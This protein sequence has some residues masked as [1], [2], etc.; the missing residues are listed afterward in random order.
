MGLLGPNRAIFAHLDVLY[1]TRLGSKHHIVVQMANVSRVGITDRFLDL[2]GPLVAPKGPSLGKSRRFEAP[3][4]TKLGLLAHEKFIV[5][6]KVTRI[7][8][9]CSVWVVTTGTIHFGP[10]KWI[11]GTF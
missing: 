3:N 6:P 5:W 7:G 9:E 4:S 10:N 1:G 11:V 2:W 8:P